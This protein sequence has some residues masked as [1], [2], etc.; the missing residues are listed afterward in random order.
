VRSNSYPYPGALQ[1][2]QIARTASQ[3]R[4]VRSRE[5]NLTLSLSRVD[6]NLSTYSEDGEGDADDAGSFDWLADFK[7]G[8]PKNK[9]VFKACVH[10]KRAHLACD[11]ER[12]CKRSVC[13]GAHAPASLL[14]LP[15]DS[16]VHLGKSDSCVDVEHKKRGRPKAQKTTGPPSR[17]GA[18]PPG[19]AQHR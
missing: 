10:C 5:S 18:L 11:N 14:N 4:F 16:C 9:P 17:S 12:P 8:R 6:S 13:A 15:W 3:E 7:D 19:R 2:R 1:A